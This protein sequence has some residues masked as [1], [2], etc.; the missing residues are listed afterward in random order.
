MRMKAKGVT[1]KLI[2]SM[3]TV[4]AFGSCELPTAYFNWTITGSASLNG[5]PTGNVKLAA[6]YTF[7]DSYQETVEEPEAHDAVLVTNVVDLG[8]SGANFSL[9]FSTETLDPTEGHYIYLIM[10]QDTN[11]DSVHDQT[12]DYEYVTAQY[13][14]PVFQ[15]SIFCQYYWADSSNYFMGTEYG[16][17]QSIG[18]A[19]YVHVVDAP[20]NNARIENLFP[21]W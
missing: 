3:L 5:T 15:D 12:E 13:G 8:T 18:L 17:N 21:W 2:F 6:F 1:K 20:N 7:D 11:S 16:W 19:A 10:W 14:C 4:F 9:T